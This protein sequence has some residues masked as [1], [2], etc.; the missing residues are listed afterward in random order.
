[1]IYHILWKLNDQNDANLA[2]VT[3]MMRMYSE[4]L[5]SAGGYE[6]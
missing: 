6:Q 5:R 4:D 3:D 1:M 2:V